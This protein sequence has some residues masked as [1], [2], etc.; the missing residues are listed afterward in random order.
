MPST[1]AELTELER[2]RMTSP[3]TTMPLAVAVVDGD[4]EALEW[5]IQLFDGKGLEWRCNNGVKLSSLAAERGKIES[6][7]YLRANGCPLDEWTCWGA[8][9]K[10]TSRCCSGHIRTGARGTRRR[11]FTRR[12]EGTRKSSSGRASERVPVGRVHVRGRSAGRAPG[13]AAVGVSERVPVG[14]VHVLVQ[15]W[16]APG[17]V[18]VGRVRT[19][20][21]GIWTRARGRR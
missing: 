12:T 21:R 7:T 11:A 16:R 13:G 1:R 3:A 9:R 18:A 15:Q 17:D 8:A 6:L 2:E 20:A 4:V 5:L 10:A 14:R 19:G